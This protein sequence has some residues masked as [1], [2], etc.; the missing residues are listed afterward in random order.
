MGQEINEQVL[1]DIINSAKV[2]A[3]NASESFIDSWLSESMNW[4]G[5]TTTSSPTTTALI[6]AFD[7]LY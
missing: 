4:L 6:G 1:V 2:E 3:D 5:E 7:L